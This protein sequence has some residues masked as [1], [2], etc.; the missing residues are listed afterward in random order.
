M[1]QLVCMKLVKTVQLAGRA[2][3]QSRQ[4]ETIEQE[5]TIGGT[6]SVCVLILHPSS[7]CELKLSNGN[8]CGDYL[9]RGSLTASDG[10]L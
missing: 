6:S 5:N 4:A 8:S 10:T 1:V 2:N 9:F 3:A 7:C